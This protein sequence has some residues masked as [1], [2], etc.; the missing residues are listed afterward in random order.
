M[1]DNVLCQ[2]T[3]GCRPGGIVDGTGAVIPR[4]SVVIRNGRIAS[5]SSG[6]ASAP[7]ARQIDAHGMTVMPGFIDDHRHVIGGSFPPSDPAQ[8]L[9]EQSVSPRLFTAEFVQLARPSGGG[10]AGALRVDPARMD[11]SRPPHRPTVAAVAIPRRL[12]LPSEN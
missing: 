12:A 10:A 11:Q 3:R 6:T 5:V 9:K 2:P 7:G 8:W 1:S 4:G